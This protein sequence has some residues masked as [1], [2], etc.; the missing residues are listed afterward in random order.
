[1]TYTIQCST[2][3]GP[4]VYRT[5]SADYAIWLADRLAEDFG[6]SEVFANQDVEPVYQ[7]ITV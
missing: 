4:M 3:T 1:M 7:S 5:E 2:E 6:N